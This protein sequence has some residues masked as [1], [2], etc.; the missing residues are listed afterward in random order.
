MPF[1]FRFALQRAAG[2]VR[3]HDYH[4]IQLGLQ[5]LPPGLQILGS[6]RLLFLLFFFGE[7]F[8]P[9]FARQFVNPFN[10]FCFHKIPLFPIA[11]TRCGRYKPGPGFRPVPVPLPAAIR[12]D[13]PMHP[14]A[15]AGLLFVTLSL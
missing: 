13:R 10:Q 4:I 8:G 14:P 2:T 9:L 5:I 7:S 15:T 1:F 12:A 11:A 6:E 3:F